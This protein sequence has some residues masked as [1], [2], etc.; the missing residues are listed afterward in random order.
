MVT[1]VR[2]GLNS[3][4][5]FSPEGPGGE[6]PPRQRS[7]EIDGRLRSGGGDGLHFTISR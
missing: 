3:N 5:G 6:H 2:H 4:L 7:G 1:N